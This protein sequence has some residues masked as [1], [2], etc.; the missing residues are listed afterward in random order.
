MAN[1][2]YLKSFINKIFDWNID[3]IRRKERLKIF[4]KYKNNKISYAEYITLRKKLENK[5]KNYD[6]R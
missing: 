3:R 2:K 5:Y 4:Y 1:K 6:N